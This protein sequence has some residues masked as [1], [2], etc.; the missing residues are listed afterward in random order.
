M[1]LSLQWSMTIKVLRSREAMEELGGE[2]EGRYLKCPPSS[3]IAWRSWLVY[4]GRR[5]WTVCCV[6]CHWLLDGHF[7]MGI[8][9]Q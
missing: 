7:V 6:V 9:Y 4:G 8:R 2:L 5:R 3:S 1:P